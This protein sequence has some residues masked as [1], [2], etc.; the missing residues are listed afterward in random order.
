MLDRPE[1]SSTRPSVEPRKM[2]SIRTG[3]RIMRTPFGWTLTA[4]TSLPALCACC[5]LW[6]APAA[7]LAAPEQITPLPVVS[8][9]APAA[10]TSTTNNSTVRIGAV[11]F[12]RRVLTLLAM[13]CLVGMI[14]GWVNGGPRETR[15]RLLNKPKKTHLSVL[16][17]PGPAPRL[18]PRDSP[19]AARASSS[20]AP[21]SRQTPAGATRPRVV[22]YIAAF[23]DSAEASERA[24]VDYLLMSSDS[25]GESLDPPGELDASLRRTG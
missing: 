4:R 7:A 13:G 24:R 3:K 10:A 18:I 25:V 11:S 6:C 5:A 21:I 22:D 17:P 19:N 1:S 23:S 14:A 15:F 9:P 16:V 12:D 20:R 8:T 2:P